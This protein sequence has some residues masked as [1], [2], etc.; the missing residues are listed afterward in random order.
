MKNDFW[1]MLKALFIREIFTFLF[2]FFYHAEER[3]GLI[4]ELGLIS[5]LMTSETKQQTITVH[6][7]PNI[8]RSKGKQAMKFG[9]LIEYNMINIFLEK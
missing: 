5:K 2:W 6:K 8:T 1:L 3:K 9:K 4:R 7:L